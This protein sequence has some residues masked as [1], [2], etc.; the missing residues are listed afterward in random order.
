M[1]EN[2]NQ[3]DSHEQQKNEQAYKTMQEKNWNHQY[4]QYYLECITNG[5]LE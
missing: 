2:K 5:L 3:N 4:L 1:K